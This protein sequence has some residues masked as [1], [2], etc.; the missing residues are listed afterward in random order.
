MYI[1]SATALRNDYGKI[2]AL[3]KETSEPVYITLNGDGDTVIMGLE[4][5]EKREQLLLLR[6]RLLISEKERLSGQLFPLDEADKKLRG[7]F[8]GRL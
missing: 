8:D 2:A 6:E 7:K 4:A 1:K 5:F 3:A